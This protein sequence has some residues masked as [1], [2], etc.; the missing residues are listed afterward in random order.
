MDYNN[1]NPKERDY[2][3]DNLD[4]TPGPWAIRV[5][6]DGFVDVGI[7][8]TT[9]ATLDLGNTDPAYPQREAMANARLIAAAPELLEALEK[10]LWSTTQDK[11]IQYIWAGNARS[12]IA[13]ARGES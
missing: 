1:E 7:G 9:I 8:V 4:P 5:R 3:N 13:K 12:V 11:T 6:Q 10:L 2:S